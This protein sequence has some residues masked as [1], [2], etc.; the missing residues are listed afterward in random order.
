MQS[1]GE[2]EAE[3]YEADYGRGKGDGCEGSHEEGS[4]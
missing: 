2:R 3:G 1:N 4:E